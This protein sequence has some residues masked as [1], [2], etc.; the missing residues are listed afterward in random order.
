MIYFLLKKKIRYT[1][2]PVD[3]LS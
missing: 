1:Q 3:F 2:M